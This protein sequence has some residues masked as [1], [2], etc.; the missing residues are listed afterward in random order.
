MKH[1]L[2]ALGKRTTEETSEVFCVECSVVWCRDL[3][4][5]TEWAKTTGSIW[6]VGMEKDGECKIDRQNKKCSCG[7]RLGEGRIMLKVIR[8]KKRNLLG[9]WLRRNCLLKDALEG[10]GNG[11]NVRGRRRYQMIDNIMINWLYEDMK[12][13][14]EKRVDWR[15]PSFQ[16]KICPWAEHYDWLI[17]WYYK[18]LFLQRILQMGQL[19]CSNMPNI[20][21]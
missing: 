9:H 14:A 18:T 12:R 4:T 19:L 1:F 7:R 21:F 2:R 5:K 17:D 20:K 8:K 16:W 6:D 3:D 10:T 11:K 13:K 15:M